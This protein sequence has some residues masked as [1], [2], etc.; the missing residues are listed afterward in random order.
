MNELIMRIGAKTVRMR[1]I[2]WKEGAAMTSIDA[3]QVTV[4]AHEEKA[5]VFSWNR[6]TGEINRWHG[7]QKQFPTAD[8]R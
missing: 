4:T 5:R 1:L 6:K 2:T 8:D 7:E 3:D